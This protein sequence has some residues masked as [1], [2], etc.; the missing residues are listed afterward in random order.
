M[1]KCAILCD[2]NPG[3]KSFEHSKFDRICN[4]HTEKQ[5]VKKKYSFKDYKFCFKTPTATPTRHPT[6]KPSKPSPDNK[7]VATFL[8]TG[9]WVKPAAT[10]WWKTKSD[11]VVLNDMYQYCKL[12][13]DGKADARQKKF[14]C[15]KTG[16]WGKVDLCK[17]KTLRCVKQTKFVKTAFGV[18]ALPNVNWSVKFAGKA[19]VGCGLSLAR[20]VKAKAAN[21]YCQTP[22]GINM[23]CN[24]N[25][26]VGAAAS[27]QLF[28]F[29]R[30]PNRPP[31]MFTISPFQ[32]SKLC[33]KGDGKCTKGCSA[34]A[35]FVIIP[36]PTQAGAWQITSQDK[37]PCSVSTTDPK[38]PF[39]CGEK[40]A[41]QI[42]G[43]LDFYIGKGATPKKAGISYVK[44][45]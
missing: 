4:L 35:V 45:D 19:C 23:A 16:K 10:T 32:N 34:S 11:S 41:A 28:N 12:T 3:C 7:Y 40:R 1:G 6:G 31:T 20:S 39:A 26:T 30:L 13:R 42:G 27:L 44:S 43:A 18:P 14:C 8:A 24:G 15:G 33:C 36:S 17:G 21:Q 25:K 38:R 9:C 29:A 37:G 2:N 22:D 5:P